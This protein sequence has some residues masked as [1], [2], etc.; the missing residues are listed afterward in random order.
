MSVCSRIAANITKQSKVV[1]CA[2]GDYYKHHA[3]EVKSDSQ[4]HRCRV[5][6]LVLHGFVCSDGEVH[7][8]N[9]MCCILCRDIA[10]ANPYVTDL[11]TLQQLHKR[12]YL[13]YL[14]ALAYDWQELAKK[15]STKDNSQRLELL[16]SN[17]NDDGDDGS[18]KSFGLC[19]LKQ[20][21]IPSKYY[22]TIDEIDH[23]P[24]QEKVICI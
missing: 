1:I 24:K 10:K 20:K 23:P 12:E 16:L 21:E 8:L 4:T 2:A 5:C 17:D 14:E 18:E 3:P 13:L 9:N 22:S 6:N 15:P 7:D 11:L 19:F